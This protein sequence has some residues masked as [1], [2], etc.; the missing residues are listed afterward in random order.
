VAEMLHGLVDSRQL[1]IVG[2]VFLLCWIELLQEYQGLL[3]VL[4]TLLQHGTHSGS[5]GVC[6]E[7]K[8]RV[9]NRLALF[10][11]RVEIWRQGDCIIALLICKLVF[12]KINTFGTKFVT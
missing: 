7:C 4:D 2:A 9:T 8:W 12:N 1:Y 6:D 11:G 3:G 5:G 10:K